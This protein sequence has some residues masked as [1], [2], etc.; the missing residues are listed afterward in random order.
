MIAVSVSVFEVS[1]LNLFLI[2][3]CQGVLLLLLLSVCCLLA[4]QF[5]PESW[6]HY[7]VCCFWYGH[8]HFHSGWRAGGPLEARGH[9]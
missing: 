6:L 7:F 9:L 1:L 5:L 2:Y 8:L 4:G 3:C